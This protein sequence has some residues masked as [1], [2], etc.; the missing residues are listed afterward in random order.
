MKNRRA[1]AILPSRKG[2]VCFYFCCALIRQRL[3]GDII[4]VSIR[5]SIASGIAA[6]GRRA[7]VEST[8]SNI[9]NAIWDGNS[10]QAD[11][12]P[13]GPFPNA[14]DTA[15]DVDSGQAAAATKGAPSYAGDATGNVDGHQASAVLK[16][17]FSNAGDTTGDVDSG[18]AAAA[19][20]GAL[21]Y[22]GDAVG[23][24]NRCQAAAANK[25]TITNACDAA[26]DTYRNQTPTI[27]K[28]IFPNRANRHSL[29][30]CGNREYGFP[31]NVLR[32]GSCVP[33]DNITKTVFDVIVCDRKHF[34]GNFILVSI[35]F[36]ET[37]DI[38][39]DGR[40]ATQESIF[41]NSGNAAWD[42]NIS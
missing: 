20:K 38:P 21:S 35:R 42:D 29:H 9:G 28:G 22:A 15:G 11:A 23:D 37:S 1:R 18:Q 8:Y 32:D 19:I 12:F 6:D 25:G 31:P 24:I 26:G 34:K 40:R 39:V 30:L 7:A 10:S 4:L 27:P 16:D 2:M 41:P 36:S 5:F 17:P 14:G 3:K 13:K 33:F